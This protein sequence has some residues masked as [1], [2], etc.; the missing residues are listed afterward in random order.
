[1]LAALA[2]AAAMK[3]APGWQRWAWPFRGVGI[4][5][6]VLLFAFVS[7]PA[8]PDRA[9]RAPARRLRRRRDRRPG[10]GHRPPIELTRALT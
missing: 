6:A 4:G 7:A 9:V 2:L 8:R 1:V 3:R 5:F 10:P